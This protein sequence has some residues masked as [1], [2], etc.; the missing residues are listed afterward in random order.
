MASNL[1]QQQHRAIVHQ[2]ASAAQAE[3]TSTVDFEHQP[4][5][6]AEDDKRDLQSLT[7]ND[8]V[9]LQADLTGMTAA[10]V[11][12]E[13][14]GSQIQQDTAQLLA[15]LDEE[16][17]KL[18]SDSAASYYQAVKKCPLEVSTERRLAFLECDA[19]N[20]TL[21]AKRLAGHWELRLE[22]LGPE[23]CYLP[24]VL[25]GAMA[26][27]MVNIAT[28]KVHRL[29]PCADAAGRGIIYMRIM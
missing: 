11:P 1:Q 14:L 26:E 10:G 15:S 20:A 7:I 5:F 2:N 24:M 29:L 21:A 17:A 8:L 4:K 18:P 16:L 13:A 19:N 3:D 9:R 6:T 23:K 28:R 25:A 12:G 22:F 27:E